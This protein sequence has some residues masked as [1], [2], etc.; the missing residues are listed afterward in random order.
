MEFVSG[1]FH[2]AYG[3]VVHLS[4]RFQCSS[5]ATLF[6]DWCAL[7]GWPDKPL[8]F[9]SSL[10]IFHVFDFLLHP[11]T[12]LILLSILWLW[13]SGGCIQL[14]KKITNMFRW[15]YDQCLTLTSAGL[16][17]QTEVLDLSLFTFLLKQPNTLLSS[18][19]KKR[20][21][22]YI[23]E[24]YGNFWAWNFT[25]ISCKIDICRYG[26]WP[27]VQRRECFYS[28]YTSPFH[29]CRFPCASSGPGII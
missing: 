22:S 10:V 3:F 4:L 6:L 14:E 12:D 29:L 8:R 15:M 9:P 24:R 11:N 2:L 21:W 23:M 13:H 20:L 26:P 18:I 17:R 28:C 16:S 25:S 1:P 27:P 5:D 19:K 7:H